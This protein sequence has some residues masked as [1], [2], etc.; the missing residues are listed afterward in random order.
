MTCKY[1]GGD[2][3]VTDTGTAN[4]FVIRKRLCIMCNQSFFTIE[5]D[6]DDDVEATKVLNK[7]KKKKDVEDISVSKTYTFKKGERKPK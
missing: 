5:E 6:F 7:L 4:D 1:C 2:T 3:K